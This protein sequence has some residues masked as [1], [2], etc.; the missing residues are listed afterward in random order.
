MLTSRSKSLPLHPE[1]ITELIQI[2]QT[3]IT[4]IF[5]LPDTYEDPRWA[6]ILEKENARRK[7]KGK[8]TTTFFIGDGFHVHFPHLI[9]NSEQWNL[10]HQEILKRVIE[11]EWMKDVPLTNNN[12]GS[13]TQIIDN[14]QH[15]P[16]YMY[17]GSKD[18]LSKPYLVSSFLDE[19]QNS[20]SVSWM[21]RNRIQDVNKRLGPK[22]ATKHS[23]QLLPM[24][25]CI[26]NYVDSFD[27]RTLGLQ[28]TKEAQEKLEEL[29]QLR[30]KHE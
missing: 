30:E 1:H 2:V 7:K 21:F 19:N 22:R 27:A 26:R 20:T 15:K 11:S 28:Y 14:V 29:Q 9:I 10:L 16:W 6:V 4:D 24:L 13:Y 3:V 25:M 23:T 8:N 5:V 18:S 12:D 17:G